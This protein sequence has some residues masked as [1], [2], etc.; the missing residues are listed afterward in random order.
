MKAS[1]CILAHSQGALERSKK[2][3]EALD[4]RED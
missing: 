2:H 3:V 1:Y 4:R